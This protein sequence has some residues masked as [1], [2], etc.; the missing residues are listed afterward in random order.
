LGVAIAALMNPGTAEAW[1]PGRLADAERHLQEGA[2]LAK[3]IGRPYVE[4]DCLA[5]LGFAP[6]IGP[7][8]TTKRR[9][10]EAITL[11]ER[12]GWD[13]EWVIARAR[14]AGRHAD[15]DR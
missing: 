9:C 5:Q 14:H 15:L 13:A 12:Y 1:S 2:A 6:K 10:P 8:A 3:E 4:V 11:A 7:F